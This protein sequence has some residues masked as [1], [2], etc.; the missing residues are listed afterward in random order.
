MDGLACAGVAVIEVDA[1]G[2]LCPLPAVRARVALGRARRGEEV[3]VL[4]T[5]PEAP[6]DL[7]AIAADAGR[8]LVAEPGPGW[9]RYRLRTATPPRRG[10]APPDSSPVAGSRS[11]AWTPPK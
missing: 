7:G 4:A 5:D 6:I 2:E 8:T 10:S 3:V 1:R 9:T 11:T